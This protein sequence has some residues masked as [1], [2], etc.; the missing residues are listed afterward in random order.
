MERRYYKLELI[1]L[2]YDKTFLNSLFSEKVSIV[3]PTY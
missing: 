1:S 3:L 2:V